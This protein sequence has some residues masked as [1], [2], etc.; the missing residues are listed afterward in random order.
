MA[1]NSSLGQARCVEK[2][3]SMRAGFLLISRSPLE[4]TATSICSAAIEPWQPS[5][6]H[7]DLAFLVWVN[8]SGAAA[9][10]CNMD[11]IPPL[12]GANWNGLLTGQLI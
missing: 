8:P 6:I 11:C 1:G 3:K 10:L 9:L 4:H 2:L 12:P 5:D 7:G